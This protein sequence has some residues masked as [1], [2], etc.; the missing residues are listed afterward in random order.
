[1]SEF[2]AL[3]VHGVGQQEATYADDAR[4]NLRKVL[5]ARGIK[6]HFETVHWAPIADAIQRAFWER[7]KAAGSECNAGQGISVFTLS[8][9]IMYCRNAHFR[10]QVWGEIERGAAR[11]RGHDYVCFA[12]SLGG[13]AFTDH[14]RERGGAERVHLVTMGCNLGIFNLGMQFESIPAL[15]R[16]TNL[17]ERS[18]ILGWGLTVHPELAHVRDVEVNVGFTGLAHTR[19]W[20]CDSLWCETIPSLLFPP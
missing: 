16:W 10:S 8:D 9:A 15:T 6:T 17:W 4:R 12:H 1:M 18:D 19:F 13:L 3:F 5:N 11:F 2:R 20:S 14:L 7:V